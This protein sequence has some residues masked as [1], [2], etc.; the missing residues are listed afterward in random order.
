MSGGNGACFLLITARWA[1][2]ECWPAGSS[3]GR[4]VPGRP[5][6]PHLLSACIEQLLRP[7]SIPQIDPAAGQA[8]KNIRVMR[9]LCVQVF[10]VPD[11]LARP[12]QAQAQ[13]REPKL[14]RERDHAGDG[15]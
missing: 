5:G 13:S 14:S 2:N 8:E 6:T 9:L 7:F 11:G 12:P 1:P 3:P 4:A 15:V 10:K